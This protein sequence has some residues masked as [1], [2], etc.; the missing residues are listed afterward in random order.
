MGVA[1]LLVIERRIGE[2][3][4]RGRV[5]PRM[6]EGDHGAPSTSAMTPGSK[7]AGCATVAA[8]PA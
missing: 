8:A 2:E 3:R 7:S 6:G 4:G 1:A 5:G